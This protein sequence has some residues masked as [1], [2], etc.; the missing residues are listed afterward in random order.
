MTRSLLQFHLVSLP[1]PYETGCV[2]YEKEGDN[3]HLYERHV[4]QEEECCE[5]CVA[6][7]WL[8][9]CGCFSKM[10]AVKHKMTG[11]VC[12]YVTH[13]EYFFASK[14]LSIPFRFQDVA[15]S[16]RFAFVFRAA[17][18]SKSEHCFLFK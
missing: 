16:L 8:K 11:N 15:P 6:A 7:T 13:C 5:A 12:D 17:N 10:Y 4:I 2:D 18:S 14:L 1:K 3:E 9:H